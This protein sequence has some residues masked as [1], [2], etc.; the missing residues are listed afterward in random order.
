MI[1]E[2]DSAGAREVL[3]HSLNRMPDRG[4]PFDYTNTQTVQLLFEVGEKERAL[5]VANILSKRSDELAAYYIVKRE[6]GREL[7]I[8]IVILGELQRVLY[9]YGETDLA[10]KMETRYNKYAAAF[11]NRTDYNRSDF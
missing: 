7:Q 10:K 9:Q 1:A 6:Y 5:E 4:V 8:P 3:L 2:G 11:Q